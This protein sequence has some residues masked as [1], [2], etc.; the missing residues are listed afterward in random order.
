[1]GQLSTLIRSKYLVDVIGYNKI[2]GKPFSSSEIHRHILT[3]L[4]EK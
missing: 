3:I 4:K 2:A 1:M